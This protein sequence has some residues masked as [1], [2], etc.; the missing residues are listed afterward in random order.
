MSEIWPAP[1]VL[2]AARLVTIARDRHRLEDLPS[3]GGAGSGAPGRRARTN[4]ITPRPL[5]E[6]PQGSGFDIEAHADRDA[7]LAREVDEVFS[8]H[9]APGGAGGGA[10]ATK[11]QPKGIPMRVRAFRRN[12]P[13][14]E[15]NGAAGDLGLDGTRLTA[16][17]EGGRWVWDDERGVDVVVGAKDPSG[18][19]GRNV[20]RWAPPDAYMIVI[21]YGSA[22]GSSVDDGEGAGGEG[23]TE[24]T[25][26]SG[27]QQGGSGNN[28]DGERQASRHGEGQGQ[29]DRARAGQD[30]NED[31][32][33]IEDI[34]FGDDPQAEAL[35]K[36]FEE[37]LGAFEEVSE[38]EADD[39]EGGATYGRTGDDTSAEGR[40]SGGDK[41]VRG[42]GE[43]SSGRTLDG[44][45]VARDDVAGG[46]KD[47]SVTTG[48]VGGEKG[49][50]EGGVRGGAGFLAFLGLT[51]SIPENYAAAVEIGLAVEDANIAGFGPKILEKAAE[52][53]AKKLAA[54]ATRRALAREVRIQAAER[55]RV[56][57]KALKTGE[58]APKS[59]S[60]QERRLL[61]E[62][63]RLTKEEQAK[64]MRIIHWEMQRRMFQST[65][66]AA[67][68][69]TKQLRRALMKTKN[70]AKRAEIEERLAVAEHMEEV[71]SIQPIA[72]RLPINHHL[73][74]QAFPPEK[75]PARWKNSG[76]RFNDDGFPDF[77]PFAMT[78]PNGQKKVRIDLTGG[79]TPDEKVV[80]AMFG[81]KKPPRGYTWHHHEVTG[82]M[83]LIPTDLHN[84]AKHTGGVAAWKHVRGELEYGN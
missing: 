74:G 72:G 44:V 7:E 42:G 49:G 79:R 24:D 50:S 66:E 26:R 45:D 31:L 23:G 59:L 27:T 8:I 75:L 63:R 9:L 19:G 55:M 62:L 2:C 3:E 77:E 68:K 38:G 4:S 40:G 13:A 43:R 28:S 67:Q 57:A 60:R 56:L 47:H 12:G 64:A 39:I 20:Q 83:M 70:P 51:L 58:K 82:D 29:G 34:S 22:V 48:A 18:K 16:R 17:K 52:K 54:G 21:E 33:G 76:L 35:A 80:N 81:W 14:V 36:E 6:L 84:A 25:G 71:A 53:G 15:W 69:E 11:K 30:S 1:L 32:E 46:E 5:S 65:L 61:E 37:S 41:A 78:L 10:L 73:A